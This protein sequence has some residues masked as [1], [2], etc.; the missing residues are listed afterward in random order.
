MSPPIT[1]FDKW[2]SDVGIVT[3]FIRLVGR[4]C[5][6]AREADAA[7]VAA[8]SAAAAGTSPSTSGRTAVASV[9]LRRGDL[10][11]AIPDAAVLTVDASRAGPA[12][13]AAGLGSK[14]GNAWR[15]GVGLALALVSESGAGPA[16]PW[17]P[18]VAWL[19]EAVPG[20]RATHPALWPAGERAL[21]AGTAAGAR[22]GKWGERTTRHAPAGVGAASA[23]ARAFVRRHPALFEA[24]ALAF[25]EAYA[26][27][28]AYS[29][30]LGSDPPIAALVPVWD[31]LDHDPRVWDGGA[32]VALA[33]D[34]AA[35]ELRMTAT[36]PVPPGGVVFN[37][38][39]DELGPGECVRR[40][41]WAPA[42]AAAPGE[43]LDFGP[44]ELGLAAL[45][46]AAAAAASAPPRRR[47]GLF[48]LA[49]IAA[50]GAGGGRP[51]CVE[52]ESGAPS[53]GLM[54]AAAAAAGAV[55]RKTDI[56]GTGHQAAAVRV[57]AAL[58][59]TRATALKRGG[60]R[61]RACSPASSGR[62]ALA[63]A[64]REAEGRAVKMMQGWC[65]RELRALCT[66]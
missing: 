3:P 40:Y 39:G 66:K 17:A 65:L 57:V 50:A 14:V 53:E 5:R 42:P 33:H 34:A 37:C 35:G 28:G 22:L 25:L 56:R 1:P 60:A 11:A 9:S 8:A 48:K 15:E 36:R 52:G 49:T 64:V 30:T 10:I 31:A 13:K 44:G 47:V 7:A 20:L 61:A 38:Y 41:G 32:G 23:L 46:A 59:A 6:S 24:P 29:F 45:A 51:L 2:C 12:L 63:A 55:G 27:V 43:R 54:D 19:V 4:A 16:S 62:V 58:A 18:Y 21:L 26:L